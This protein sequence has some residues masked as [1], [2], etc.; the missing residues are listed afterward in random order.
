MAI[1]PGLIAKYP[2][3]SAIAKSMGLQCWSDQAEMATS[4]LFILG[5]VLP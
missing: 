2:L 1:S 5:G 3:V 4:R